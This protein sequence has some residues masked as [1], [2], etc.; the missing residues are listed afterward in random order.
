[1]KARPPG[2]ILA[3][4]IKERGWTQQELANKTGL[5]LKTINA[6]INGKIF[7]TKNV[8]EKLANALD[9]SKTFWLNLEEDYRNND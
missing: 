1:M 4:E 2:Y 5:S 3:E 6:L 7:L 8:A 9:T